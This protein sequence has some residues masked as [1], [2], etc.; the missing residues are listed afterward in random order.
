MLYI[1]YNEIDSNQCAPLVLRQL[2]DQRAVA[3]PA[4]RDLFAFRNKAARLLLW[5]GFALRLPL[6]FNFSKKF[7]QFLNSIKEDDNV[8]IFG[9]GICISARIAFAFCAYCKAQKKYRWIWDSILRKEEEDWLFDL[10][11]Y[12][13]VWTFDRLDAQKYGL[14]YKNT[15]CAVPQKPA[16]DGAFDCDLYFVGYDRGRYE[17]LNELYESLVAM[18]LTCKFL[19]V[20]DQ[21]SPKQEKAVRLLDK[22]VSPEENYKNISAARAVLDLP[23]QGQRGLTQRVLEGLFIGRKVVTSN[24]L[25]GEEALFNKDDVFVLGGRDISG[26]PDFIRSPFVPANTAPYTINEWIKSFILPE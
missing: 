24:P 16:K 19:L 15:V 26:L 17:R 21:S 20:R 13:D 10:K 9:S 18:G 25:A 7:R 23:T 4:G 6:P 3:V 1:F 14:T 12:F 22:G 11:K 5:L 2:D 8:L